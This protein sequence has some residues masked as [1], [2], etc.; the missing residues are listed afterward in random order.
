[1]TDT[2]ASPNNPP[3]TGPPTSPKFAK[4]PCPTTNASSRPKPSRTYTYTPPERGTI[5]A[6]SAYV[7]APHS[8]SSPPSTHTTSMSTGSG[9]RPAITAGVRKIPPPIVEPTSTAT[10][11]Q[12]PSR[13]GR[14][15]PQ[16]SII[17]GSGGDVGMGAPNIHFRTHDATLHAARLD[18]GD[19]HVLPHHPRR[20]RPHHRLGDGMRRALAPLQRHSASAIRPP[21]ADR[22]RTSARRSRRERLRGRARRVR[23]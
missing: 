22:V 21:D 5:A 8:A 1:M 19:R 7:S 20:H 11:L 18:R 15:S 16:R 14:R 17:D 10:A 12:K 13:R 3:R 6:S 23:L 2:S 4:L 9:T